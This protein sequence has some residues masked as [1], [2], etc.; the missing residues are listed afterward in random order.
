MKRSSIIK[1]LRIN[2][3]SGN[4]KLSNA[5]QSRHN[6]FEIAITTKAWSL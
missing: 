5:N 3:I 4:Y 6:L 2:G 1:L